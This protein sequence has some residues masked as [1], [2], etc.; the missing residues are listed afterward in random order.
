[1]LKQE[2]QSDFCENLPQLKILDL[3]DNKIEKLPDDIAYLQSLIRLD[4]SN[5]SINRYPKCAAE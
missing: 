1:M 4:L 3:R 2:I 5:N